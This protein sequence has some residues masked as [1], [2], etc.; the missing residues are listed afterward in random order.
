MHFRD[1]IDQN[2]GLTTQYPYDAA[3]N[4]S[5]SGSSSFFPFLF[6]GMDLDCPPQ[7]LPA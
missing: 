4:A 5:L 7:K 3:G 1:Q 2:L 6:D